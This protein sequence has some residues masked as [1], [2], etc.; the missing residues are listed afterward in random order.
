MNKVLVPRWIGLG[1]ATVAGAVWAFV[2]IASLIG[3][4]DPHAVEG[5]AVEGTALAV[6]ALVCLAG[7][8]LAW[9]RARLGGAVLIVAGLALSIFAAVSA[10]R[11]QWA[12]VL[13]SGAPFLVAGVLLVVSRRRTTTN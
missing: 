5:A 4:P 13:T 7:V 12:A 10:G 9:W 8:G 11:R 3:G 1:L 6:L 2:L